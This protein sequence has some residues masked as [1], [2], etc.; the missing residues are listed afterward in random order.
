MSV[1]E[2]VEGKELG[3]VEGEEGEGWE[4]LGG[5]QAAVKHLS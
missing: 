3:V 1:G 2:D 4:W 5:G